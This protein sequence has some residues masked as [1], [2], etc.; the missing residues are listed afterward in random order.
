MRQA[1]AD[2][3]SR[4]TGKR[5]ARSRKPGAA[6]DLSSKSTGKRPT[7]AKP[8][9]APSR[10]RKAEKN[11]VL[12]SGGNPQIARADGDAPVQAYLAAMP[13]WKRQ[14]GAR[15]DK[16]IVRAVP[17]VKKAVKWNSPFYGLEGSGWFLN[18]HC[19]TKYLKVAFFKGASLRPLPPGESKHQEVR[20][21]DIREKDVLDEHQ[22]TDWVKQAAQLPG[23]SP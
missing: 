21:L 22:F 13:G 9:V 1:M 10:G 7:V 8:S 4:S 3:T 16:L 6:K 12:L 20:Y 19:F 14:L 15:L 11:V 18:F 2:D 5:A 17:S 23:W